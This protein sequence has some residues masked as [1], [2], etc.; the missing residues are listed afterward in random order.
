[1]LVLVLVLVVVVVVVVVLDLW[2]Q[3]KLL[4]LA[5]GGRCGQAA[6]G[7]GGARD[8]RSP[9]LQAGTAEPFALEGTIGAA[10]GASRPPVTR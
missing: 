1:V 2:G 8:V 10:F 3:R 6:E 4:P 5:C 7:R 9:N